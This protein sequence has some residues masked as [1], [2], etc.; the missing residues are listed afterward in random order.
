MVHREE[1]GVSAV[2]QERLHVRL[3]SPHVVKSRPIEDETGPSSSVKRTGALRLVEGVLE[4]NQ[5]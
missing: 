1:I 3:E 2:L 4:Q 5:G